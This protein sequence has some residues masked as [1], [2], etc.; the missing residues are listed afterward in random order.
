MNVKRGEDMVCLLPKKR[1]LGNQDTTM[2]TTIPDHNI[3]SMAQGIAQILRAG[4]HLHR[5]IGS[6]S[7]SLNWQVQ[8]YVSPYACTQSTL[9]ELVL[10]EKEDHRC[11]GRVMSSRTKFRKLSGGKENEGYKGKYTNI[12]EGSSIKKRISISQLLEGN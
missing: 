11:E 5:M 1:I 2:Y 6:D 8:F 7:C 12:L 3:L 9:C 4:E 10:F